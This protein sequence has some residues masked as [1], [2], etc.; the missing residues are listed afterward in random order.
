MTDP[1]RIFAHRT[2]QDGTYD[3]ICTVCFSTVST[4]QLEADL[5]KGE[6]EHVCHVGSDLTHVS[7]ILHFI[8]QYRYLRH[9]PAQKLQPKSAHI[10]RVR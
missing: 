5:E 4:Q 3:S 10:R 2:N 8:E 9:E 7:N 1:R 6:R